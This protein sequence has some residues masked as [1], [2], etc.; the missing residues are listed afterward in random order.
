MKKRVLR[1]CCAAAFLLLC[2][3]T[4]L[5][6][7]RFAKYESTTAYLEWS[8]QWLVTADGA[9]EPFSA[10][11]IPGLGE[12]E[13]Y[14]FEAT[15]PP[16]TANGDWL[17]FEVANLEIAV[18]LD[19]Q[20]IYRSASLQSGSTANLGQVQ[21]P[22]PGGGG[23]LV[24]ELRPLGQAQGVFPPLARLTSDP[25]DQ[26]GSIAY[27]NYY[28]IP[29][30]MTAAFFLLLCALFFLGLYNGVAVWRLL[31]L[32]FAAAGLTIAPLAVGFG[33]DF[34]PE[35]LMNAVSW[36]W[37]QKLSSL[38][39]LA[40]LLSSRDRLFWRRLGGVTLCSAAALLACY[41][42]SRASGGFLA[43]YLYSEIR[44]LFSTGVYSGLLFWLTHWLVAVCALLSAMEL[45]RKLSA[46]RAEARALAVKERVTAENYQSLLDK[47]R[48]TAVLRHEWKNQLSALRLLAEGGDAAA[49]KARL[50]ELSGM[51][52]RLD[53]RQYTE[54]RAINAIL[55]N[56]AA[57]AARQEVDF[58]CS[59][60][61]PAGLKIDEADLCTL[62]INL[63]DNAIEAASRVPAPRRREVSCHIKYHQGYLAVSC[64]NSYLGPL[65]VDEA[66]RPLTDKS[67]PGEHGLGLMQMRAVAEKYHSRLNISSD[68]ETFTAETA[69]QV[70]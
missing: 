10:D 13:Y 1:C 2:V 16:D 55:Q 46:T 54:H 24:M 64:V 23:T 43:G 32:I 47:H 44:V 57:R 49:L 61:V 31:L 30:G 41:L 42:V 21:L 34:L 18:Y 36:Q 51:L 63:L 19:G 66:G 65:R 27:A 11:G 70:P 7:Q 48:E 3:G 5:F 59:A 22:L 39:V 26:A 9:A 40:Y 68:D 38:A 6:L 56:A 52:D 62:L 58:H 28:S 4:A 45:A 25:M 69:L 53:P 17:I 37:V 67:G 20:E 29:A 50:D 60:L 8:G 15:V 14:R 33:F 35:A 12:G